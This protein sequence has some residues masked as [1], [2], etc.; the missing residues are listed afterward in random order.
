[1]EENQLRGNFHKNRNAYV[2]NNEPGI[3][4]CHHYNCYLQ[5]CILDTSGY[6]PGIKTEVLVNS[7]QEIAYP[8]F[9]GHF[10]ENNI[11]SIDARKSIVED[12][13]RFAGFG[14]ISLAEINKHGG[15]SNTEYDHYGIGWKSKFEAKPEEPVSFFTRGF[16]AGSVEA[17][18]DLPTGSLDCLQNKCIAMGDNHSEFEIV[19]LSEN[20]TLLSTPQEGSYQTSVLPSPEGNVDYSGIREALIGMPLEGSPETGL[21]EAFGVLLTNHFANYYCKI[22]YK[23]LRLFE[24]N[25]GENGTEMARDLLIEAGHVCAFNTFGGIMQSNEWNALIK[26]SLKSKEDWAH[27]ITA[28]VNAL[29]WGFWEIVD[30]IPNEKLVMKITSGYEANS[31]LGMYGSDSNEFVSFLATGGVAGIMNLVYLL[32]LPEKAPLTLDEDTYNKIHRSEG[33]FECKQLKCR[34]KGDEYDLFEATIKNR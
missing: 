33:F 23:T 32:N 1:M 24:D 19:E 7:A 27:G 22:S 31:Y 29:G 12:Y 26:P 25:M 34:A 28:V 18:Y 5:A 10:K 13:F 3:F 15:K 30:L 2:V 11:S 8:L 21:L 9:V 4:H 14:K 16:L 17:I 20:K 6:L